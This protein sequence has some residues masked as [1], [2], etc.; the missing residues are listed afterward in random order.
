MN[1]IILAAGQGTRLHP[2]T[3]NYPKSMIRLANNQTVLQRTINIIKDIDKQA[4]IS[5]V[6]GYK[7]QEIKNEIVGC[8]FIENPF[9]EFTNSIASLWFCK[10]KL[11]GETIILN[12]DVVFSKELLEFVL[13][14][15]SK[16][17][18]CLDASIKKDGDYNVQVYN[19]RVVAMSKE[20]EEYYGEYAGITKLGRDAT[21]LLKEE[22]ISM[23][24]DG[25]YNE[26]YENAL[27][28]LIL[29]NKMELSFLDIKE[30][31]WAEL[32]TINDLFLSKKITHKESLR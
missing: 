22:V 20:L 11:D 6:I 21:L 13:Q 26:W 19:D 5:V 9:Y 7:Q 18:V 31:E 23:V 25:F 27:V 2:Y 30:Y 28:Q 24:G 8:E 29:N 10:D 32:D 15:P 14:S 3:R 4:T 12:A 1:Y 17:F 16:A